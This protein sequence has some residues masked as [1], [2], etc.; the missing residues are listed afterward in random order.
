MHHHNR[1]LLAIAVF[2]W[3]NAALLCAIAFGLLK[4]L[5]RDPSDVAENVLQSLRIDTDNAAV[6]WLLAKLSVIDQQK[7]VALSAIS[8]G[9]GV[10]LLILGTGLYLEKR[11][12]EYLTI[13]V[14]ASFLPFE[15]YEL[16]KKVDPAVIVLVV[17]NVTILV[18]L[19]ITVR[20]KVSS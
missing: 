19:L 12:A 8:F 17:I 6:D 3:F 2:K 14:T 13:V 9:Y 5:H 1:G 7:I 16:A 4:L 18:Y 11:W 15:L 20:K 10:L